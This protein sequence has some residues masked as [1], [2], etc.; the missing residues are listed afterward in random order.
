MSRLI[1]ERPRR[2][3]K[4][5]ETIKGRVRSLEDL[6]QHEGMRRP[7][8][9]DLKELSDNLAPLRRYLGRQVGP[10]L[11]RCLF[12]NRRAFAHKQ[13]FAAARS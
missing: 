10:A 9:R 7:Y 2:V 6:P 3:P 8:Y 1:V 12:R 5:P 13:H 11:G 4:R